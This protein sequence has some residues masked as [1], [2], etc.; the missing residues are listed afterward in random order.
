MTPEDIERL[1]EL[2]RIISHFFDDLGES[3]DS[4]EEEGATQL[5]VA[6]LEEVVKIVRA[7]LRELETNSELSRLRRV[8]ANWNAAYRV[9]RGPFVGVRYDAG[10]AYGYSITASTYSRSARQQ[11]PAS[12][13]PWVQQPMSSPGPFHS[14]ST[15]LH[16][17]PA[18]TQSTYSSHTGSMAAQEQPSTSG[19]Q[20]RA[21]SSVSTAPSVVIDLAEDEED[22]PVGDNEQHPRPR[23]F[24]ANQGTTYRQT[25]SFR[26]RPRGTTS[27]PFTI[28]ESSG[29]TDAA[30]NP[31]ANGDGSEHRDASSILLDPTAMATST[32]AQSTNGGVVPMDTQESI[33]FSQNGSTPVD[34]SSATA[35]A[36]Q[37]VATDMENQDHGDEEN[38]VE[39][40]TYGPGNLPS[41]P[42]PD[43]WVEHRA[44][45][46][47]QGHGYTP[48]VPFRTSSLGNL[49]DLRDATVAN[50]QKGRRSRGGTPRGGGSV[51]RSPVS[52]PDLSP[53]QVAAIVDAERK[54]KRQAKREREKRN[55]QRCRDP[56]RSPPRRDDSDPSGSGSATTRSAQPMIELDRQPR[57]PTE[58]QEYEQYQQQ[59]RE[60]HYADL[61]AQQR[62]ADNQ[63][64]IPPSV[65]KLSPETGFLHPAAKVRKHVNVQGTSPAAG[66]R[67]PA[68]TSTATAT[69]G[70]KNQPT[71]DGVPSV[72]L[73]RRAKEQAGKLINKQLTEK[74]ILPRGT[75]QYDLVTHGSTR[76]T[77]TSASYSVA[78]TPAVKSGIF[79][80][81]AHDAAPS[82]Q[83]ATASRGRSPA[84]TAAERK[85]FK[86]EQQKLFTAADVD[87]ILLENARF[88][89]K[90]REEDSDSSSDSSPE[91]PR[92]HRRRGDDDP[93]YE[94]EGR[95]NQSVSSSCVA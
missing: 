60:V 14:P 57:N 6:D 22:V 59:L 48:R 76:T 9:A 21:H 2:R 40:T 44:A 33:T 13:P 15:T 32:P 29:D 86:S 95:S 67:Q 28:Y 4:L 88:L 58:Q 71:T 47:T 83:S 75:Y 18:P 90:K 41:T 50:R 63:T 12:V 94:D 62:A 42:S 66:V 45:V 46:L 10:V 89:K 51:G 69:S 24:S 20:S 93:D 87:R 30:V 49:G 23:L 61:A 72:S 53:E 43:R 85:M 54:R 38:S 26:D 1:T 74:I 19:Q 34:N 52:V 55:K 70:R 77:S 7:L 80:R 5:P 84:P 78:A 11:Q 92:H 17:S 39:I 35:Q 16:G 25:D 56:S 81:A 8:V 65:K 37:P 68:S 79:P 36:D 82:T 73:Q 91:L 3:L 64:P 31:N 27:E